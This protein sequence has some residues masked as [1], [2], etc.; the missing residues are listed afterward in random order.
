M[1]SNLKIN[2]VLNFYY[3]C[4]L[5]KHYITWKKSH[6]VYSELQDFVLLTVIDVIQDYI[7]FLIKIYHHHIS[8][9][10]LVIFIKLKRHKYRD[11][12]AI[13]L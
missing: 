1:E 13:P 5:F 10:I 11:N 9:I 7:L 8:H 4:L 12:N 6:T 2:F 3:G